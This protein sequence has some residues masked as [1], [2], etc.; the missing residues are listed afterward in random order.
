MLLRGGEGWG[1]GTSSP[2]V[3]DQI[4]ASAD[5]AGNT[6]LPMILDIHFM[7]IKYGI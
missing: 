4:F 3:P 2:F 7:I 1:G 6:P 5:A